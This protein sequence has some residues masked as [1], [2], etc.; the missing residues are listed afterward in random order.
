MK[1]IK[2]GLVFVLIVIFF[3][4]SAFGENSKENMLYAEV[5]RYLL[6]SL[7]LNQEF[8][9][10]IDKQNSLQAK[11]SVLEGTR[12]ALSNLQKEHQQ[13]TA[14]ILQ[15]MTLF[16]FNNR[17]NHVLRASDIFAQFLIHNPDMGKRFISLIQ[18]RTEKILQFSKPEGQ[19]LFDQHLEK[20]FPVIIEMMEVQTKSENLS[21]EVLDQQ[22]RNIFERAGV[23]E[24]EVE[25]V[26]IL[27]KGGYKIIDYYLEKHPDV[28]QRYEIAKNQLDKMY[29]IHIVEPGNMK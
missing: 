22:I 28:R 8:V 20:Y 2:N 10:F 5:E 29:P 11:Q 12:Q 4:V 18:K 6:I 16:E 15:G 24:Y 25:K 13:H 7:K 17:I 23:S 3:N 27:M 9:N 26:S 1:F 14:I 19:I 21:P